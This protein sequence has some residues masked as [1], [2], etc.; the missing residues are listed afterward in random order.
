VLLGIGLKC[1]EGVKDQTL[2][3]VGGELGLLVGEGG[4]GL[5]DVGLEGGLEVGDDSVGVGGGEGG[6]GV[7]A[8]GG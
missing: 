6:L 5:L 2:V 4:D 1:L 8:V 3:A 7:G